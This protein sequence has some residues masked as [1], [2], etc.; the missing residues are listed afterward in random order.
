[1]QHHPT[2][3][4]PHSNS[5]YCFHVDPPSPFRTSLTGS[6]RSDFYCTTSV[7]NTTH[8]AAKG[9]DEIL[10]NHT[11]LFEPFLSQSIHYSPSLLLHQPQSATRRYARGSAMTS[12][13]PNDYT[14]TC[15]GPFPPSSS[16]PQNFP[17]APE[18]HA[19]QTSPTVTASA[20]DRA[21]T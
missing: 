1:M 8:A 20:P 5:L 11:F 13:S 18:T 16:T 12:E 21:S 14:Q 3:A 6:Q 4:L 19:K 9:P 10:H 17:H 7:S 2:T 15:R